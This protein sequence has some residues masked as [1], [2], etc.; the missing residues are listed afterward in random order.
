MVSKK[1]WVKQTIDQETRDLL[2]TLAQQ[3]NRTVPEVIK[4]MAQQEMDRRTIG[5][6]ERIT[7]GESYD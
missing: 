1:Q 5:I 7:Q 3:M 6:L 4:Y 2:M